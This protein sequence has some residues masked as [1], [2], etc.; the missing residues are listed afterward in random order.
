MD[1]VLTRLNPRAQALLNII[2]SSVCAIICLVLIYY[3]TRA[4]WS[5]Y[6]VNYLTVT[7][8]LV[9]PKAI[10]VAIVPVGLIPLFIQFIKRTYGYVEKM[11]S[12]TG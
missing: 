5:L 10:V 12:A 8:V 7:K 6:E 2:T 9:F 11:K 3:G 1:L 4:V